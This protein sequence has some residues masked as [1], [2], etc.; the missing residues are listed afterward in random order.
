MPEIRPRR[1]LY[2]APARHRPDRVGNSLWPRPQDEVAVPT[3]YRDTPLWS[4]Q[5]EFLSIEC[6]LREAPGHRYEVRIAF[7]RGIYKSR[8]FRTREDALAF[9]SEQHGYFL[10]KWGGASEHFVK[11]RIK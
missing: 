4:L 11:L 2:A 10:T 5:K 9:A 7:L 6:V 1:R 3:T 8:V